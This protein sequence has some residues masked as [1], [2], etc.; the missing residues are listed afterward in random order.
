M[1]QKDFTPPHSLTEALQRLSLELN[2][3]MVRLRNEARYHDNF[4]HGVLDAANLAVDVLED[5]HAEATTLTRAIERRV[6]GMADDG[7]EHEQREDKSLEGEQQED[8]RQEGEQQ[9]GE[10]Q[11]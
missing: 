5:A 11:E 9:Q 8:E 1:P 4:D 6:L 7:Q 2:G 10:Q 3:L